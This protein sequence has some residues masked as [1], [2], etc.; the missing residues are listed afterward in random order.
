MIECN[1]TKKLQTYQELIVSCN[2]NNIDWFKV[3][4]TLTYIL[5]EKNQLLLNLRNK[6]DTYVSCLIS[7]KNIII[8]TLIQENAKKERV[9]ATITTT[10]NPNCNVAAPK[11]PPSP[12]HAHMHAHTRS[13]PFSQFTSLSPRIS[14]L[15][16]ISNNNNNHHHNNHSHN[17]NQ[18]ILRIRMESSSCILKENDC[19]VEN[20]PWYM[21]ANHCSN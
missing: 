2:A 1:Y 17:I 3:S 21:W 4:S 18:S 11:S 13:A 8:Q 15:S 12:A 16:S 10:T 9:L 14:I 5:N 7:M 20:I 6:Y 19:R